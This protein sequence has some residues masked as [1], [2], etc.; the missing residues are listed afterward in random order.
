M[1]VG[2]SPPLRAQLSSARAGMT[3][4]NKEEI[5]SQIVRAVYLVKECLIYITTLTFSLLAIFSAATFCF[6]VPLLIEPAL[7]T[8][9]HKFLPTNCTTISGEWMEGKNKCDWSSCREGCTKEIF[10]CWKIRVKYVVNDTAV[11]EGRLLPN[12]YGCGYPPRIVC[13][14]FAGKFGEI[15][16]EFSCYYSQVDPERVITHLDYDEISDTLVYG[17]SIPCSVFSISVIYLVLAY[18]HIYPRKEDPEV[19]LAAQ[20]TE[21]LKLKMLKEEEQNLTSEELGRKL[22][23]CVQR[24]ERLCWWAAFRNALKTT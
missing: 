13:A 15:D 21:E 19:E 18:V 9:Q 16:T 8:L 6:L 22:G 4:L 20:E 12:V 24:S 17:V 11:S 14:E 23:E 2:N 10:N 7:A 1:G 3:A 5:K